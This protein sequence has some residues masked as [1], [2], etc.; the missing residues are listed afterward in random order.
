VIATVILGSVMINEILGP[1]LTKFALTR[2]GE[3][4]VEHAG[5]FE[6]I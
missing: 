2:A 6:E 1:V 5:A 4:R 3:T